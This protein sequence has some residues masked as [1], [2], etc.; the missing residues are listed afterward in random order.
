V[1]NENK[2]FGVETKN[3]C[4]PQRKVVFSAADHKSVVTVAIDSNSIDK[5]IES[6]ALPV[7]SLFREFRIAR[8]IS[9]RE[10]S[11]RTGIDVGTLSKRER[12]VLS[13]T[14]RE[15]ESLL[16]LIYE[17][18]LDHPDTKLL[19]KKLLALIDSRVPQ[20]EAVKRRLTEFKEEQQNKI[21]EEHKVQNE[22]NW[23]KTFVRVPLRRSLAY[24]RISEGL[25]EKE[26]AQE[27]EIRPEYY[28]QIENGRRKPRPSTLTAIIGAS[29]LEIDSKPAQLLHLKNVGQYPISVND[30]Q[31]ASFGKILTYFQKLKGLSSRDFSSVLKVDRNRI[32]R[33]INNQETPSSNFLD[34]IIKLLKI[35]KKSDLA[36]LLIQKATNVHT[37]IAENILEA[38]KLS[39][40][41][42]LFAEHLSFEQHPINETE[43]GLMVNINIKRS[44][45]AIKHVGNLLTILRPSDTTQEKL[46]QNASITQHAYGEIENAYV[47]PQDLTVA[48]IAR[49]LGYSIHHPITHALLDQVDMDRIMAK[50]S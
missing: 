24:L 7:G 14:G 17:T 44:E 18:D 34:K 1:G 36:T 19:E 5:S 4:L 35:S 22:R 43:A 40:S 48:N 28:S 29:P 39:D 42:Y 10:A 13:V 27:A 41:P 26:F 46:A 45:G 20:S 21:A 37:P 23:L 25:E 16:R 38:L 49:A 47:I 50:I 15:V 9:L 31:K 11:R 32:R 12:G 6:Q 8:G 30:F 33:I 3:S 2:R